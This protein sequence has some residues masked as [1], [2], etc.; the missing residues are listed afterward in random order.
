VDG[1]PVTLLEVAR[2]ASAAAGKEGATRTLSLEEA[3]QKMGPVADAV[4]LDQIVLTRRAVEVGWEP[5]RGA[6]LDEVGRAFEEWQQAR[7]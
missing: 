6:F 5:R 7:S 2:A 3:R 4:V 1:H